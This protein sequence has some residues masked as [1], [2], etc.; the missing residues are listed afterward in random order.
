LNLAAFADEA[1]M[2]RGAGHELTSQSSV[3]QS[4]QRSAR[5]PNAESK[6]DT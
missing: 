5:Q 6:Y 1:V 3:S 2:G 4:A